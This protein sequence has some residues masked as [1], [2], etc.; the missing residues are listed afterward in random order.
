MSKVKIATIKL[1]RK[2]KVKIL[3]GK[4]RG[5]T[6]EIERVYAKQ[7][8]VLIPGLN[9]YKKH[10]Q[11]SEQTPQGGV[12]EVPRLLNISNIIFMCP[13]CNKPSKIGYKVEKNKKTRI[14]KKCN[15]KV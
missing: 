6:G 4:D 10:I 2:D 8:K 3:I 12:V 1:K 7:N 15:S 13:K 5:K 9:L 14:C 11:K